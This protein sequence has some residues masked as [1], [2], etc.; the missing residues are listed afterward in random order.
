MKFPKSFAAATI[1]LDDIGGVA[2]A[3][4]ALTIPKL[5][6]SQPSPRLE[7]LAQNDLGQNFARMAKN[8][9]RNYFQMLDLFYLLLEEENR[10]FIFPK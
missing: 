3:T 4:Y 2:R 7:P 1:E 5:P 9:G 10:D 8:L 6:A